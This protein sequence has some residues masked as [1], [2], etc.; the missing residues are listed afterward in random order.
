MFAQKTQLT[1]NTMFF[2]SQKTGLDYVLSLDP[3]RLLSPC[4]TALGKTPK[5]PTYGGWESMQIQGH[6][7]GHYISALSGFYFQTGSI[8]A[9][10]KL[11]YTVECLKSIQRSDG[12]IGGIPS[13]PF[14]TA[15]TGNFNVEL[16]NLAGYWVPWYSVH[17]IYA[18]L[19]DAYT[20]GENKDAL[21]VVKRMADWAINGSKNM[22]EAQFQKMLVCEHGG[23]C[24]VYADLYGITKDE[25]YLTMAER[26]I[27]KSVIVPA[28]KQNDNLKGLHAN[29]QMPKFIG[30][31]RLYELTGKSEYRT[32][33]EFYFNK[34]YKTRSYSIGGVSV[35]EHFTSP[36]DEKLTR[37]TC[38]T[39]DAYNMLELAEHIFSWNKDSS[40]ADY[41][42]TTLYNDILASQDPDTGC[43]AYFIGMIPGYFKIYGSKE[44]AFWCCTGTGMENPERYN[45]FIAKDFGDTIYINMFIPSTVTTDDGWKIKIETE[46]PYGQ[47][48]K[49]TVLES[50]KNPRSLKIR[51]PSWM[52]SSKKENDGYWTASKN[53][54]KNDT[55]NLDLPMKLNVRRTRDRTGNFSILYGPIVLAADLGNKN[56]PQDIVDNQSIYL[57]APVKKVSAITADLNK[58]ESWITETDSSKLT[59]TTS[60][61]S[62]LQNISYTLKPF[63]DI[64]HTR[65]TVYFNSEDTKENERDAKYEKITFDLVEPGRQQSEVDHHG[66]NNGTEMG[67]VESVDRNCRSISEKNGE[68]SYRVKFDNTKKNSIVAT[69]W[70]KDSGSIKMLLD[71]KEI[72][73]IT[74]KSDKGDCLVDIVIP[75]SEDLVKEKGK[76]NRT[77]RMIVSFKCEDEK[78]LK[79]LEL[80]VINEQ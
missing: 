52:E 7:L 57:T 1:E 45:R 54:S 43:K 64:A 14:D 36:Y 41:Y 24:K 40:V 58:P 55:F 80:R 56:M 69:F 49:V 78:S 6:S 68:F 76:T 3:D 27:D 67:Y 25:K 22:T 31:A 59:F 71:D 47:K 4:Y 19:I 5:A 8:E 30:I 50:G 21:E 33:A 20:Y 66:K 26:F 18:G 53:I 37:D 70:G 72:E 16:F 48:A 60:A 39:C 28:I 13:T 15:F 2:N 11:D 62:T 75:V 79:L 42:E 12:Y 10:K 74:L 44:N 23:M 73:T 65:Y 38:E 77:A 63:F 9:K 61:E 29:A 17:K 35:G 32:A 34:V 51:I 46:F